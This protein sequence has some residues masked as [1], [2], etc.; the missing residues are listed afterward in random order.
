MIIS[1]PIA[2]SLNYGLEDPTQTL[3]KNDYSQL[4]YLFQQN[5]LQQ[6]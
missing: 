6:I 1:N 3:F 5:K 2:R 4:Q